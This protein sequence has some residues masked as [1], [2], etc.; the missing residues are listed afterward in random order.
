M[1]IG[2]WSR[3]TL[4]VM[5]MTAALIGVGCSEQPGDSTADDVLPRILN[6]MQG[7]WV[8][9]TTNGCTDNC[10]ATIEGYTIR[11]RYQATL[12]A[13]MVRH[14]STIE[15]LDETRQLL[16][17]AGGSGAWPY[18]YGIKDGE[19]HLEVEFFIDQD[20]EWRRIYLRRSGIMDA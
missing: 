14:S 8:S 17:L 4:V 7:S 15:K 16:I 11:L 9:V 18:F 10:G 6:S 20:Q 1:K 13:P 12:D 19:E 3:R 5:G 2:K